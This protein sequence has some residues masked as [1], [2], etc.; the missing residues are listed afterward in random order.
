MGQQDKELS[1]KETLK[2]VE[3]AIK[4]IN[5]SGQVII[6]VQGGKPIF[7]DYYDRVRVG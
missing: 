5:Y 3:E 2:A 1:I 4:K 6:K 7:V